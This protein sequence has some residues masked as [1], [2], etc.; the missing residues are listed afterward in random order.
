[1]H[2][3]LFSNIFPQMT[4]D[5]PPSPCLQNSQL[6]LEETWVQLDSPGNH[7]YAWLRLKGCAPCPGCLLSAFQSPLFYLHH[8][9]SPRL[10]NSLPAG[11]L[12]PHL[13]LRSL[14]SS[15]LRPCPPPSRHLYL[16]RL[17]NRAEPSLT[18]PPCRYQFPPKSHLYSIF[19][20]TH[21]YSIFHKLYS[22]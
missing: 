4:F 13:G 6:F 11:E 10:C 2:R 14:C 20:V 7:D 12:Q 21:L 16:Y 22:K 19:I 17:G 3:S 15:A 9:C 8:G 1:M 18:L 5:F